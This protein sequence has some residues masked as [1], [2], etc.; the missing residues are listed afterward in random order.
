TY[1]LKKRH[2]FG[3]MSL[4]V[5]SPEGELIRELPG[6]KSAG[7]NI[8]AL[9]TRLPM[10]KAAPTNNRAALFGS[11]FPPTLPEG[12]YTAVLT[13]GKEEYTF[14]FEL[15]F[16][17]D[18]A[19]TYPAADRKLAHQT[20]MRLYNLTNQCGYIYYQLEAMHTQAAGLREKVPKK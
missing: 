17:P 9:P 11:A 15:V 8:V 6:G 10:P 12:T 16:D 2:T 4:A 5:Y 18:A 1:Y 7:I 3:K 20:Q 14:N 19:E 13:K